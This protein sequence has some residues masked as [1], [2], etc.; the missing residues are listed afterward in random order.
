M[1]R[2]LLLAVC[3]GMAGGATAATPVET[4]HGLS[5]VAFPAPQRIA[6]GRLHA[7]DI[8]ALKAA[9][10]REVIDLSLDSETP[11]FDEAAAM[12]RA[13]ITY[14]NLPIAGA[15]DLNPANVKRFDRL[16][17]AAGNQRTLV[18]CA[19]GNRVGAMIALRTATLG[20]KDANQAVAEGRR[21]GLKSLES[22]VRARLQT[23]APDLPSH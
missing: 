18:H 3:V 19:S 17:A 23:V 15:S 14:Y 11:D 8:A 20:G 16:L 10:V 13:G 2:P 22:A 9:G 21:W 12:Q 5:N 6:S 7:G 4:L 1:I